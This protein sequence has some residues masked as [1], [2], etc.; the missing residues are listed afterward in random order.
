MV[1]LTPILHISLKFS[2]LLWHNLLWTPVRLLPRNPICRVANRKS[3]VSTEAVA[4]TQFPIHH[5]GSWHPSLTFLKKVSGTF[6]QSRQLPAPKSLPGTTH[7]KL[8]ARKIA[9]SSTCTAR[10]TTS[11]FPCL[12]WSGSMEGHYWQGLG[13][14]RSMDPSIFLTSRKKV[15]P[16]FLLCREVIVVTLNYR[17]GALGFL[18]LGSEVVS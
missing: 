13:P 17:L 4:K 8:L 6:P 2:G 9:S 12:L 7:G 10:K 18:C 3:E 16:L 1:A 15:F 14:T 5:S 11:R